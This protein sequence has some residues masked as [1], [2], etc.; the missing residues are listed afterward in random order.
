MD[1][2]IFLIQGAKK[3]RACIETR[4]NTFSALCDSTI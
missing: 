1:K 4:A 3:A 2:C